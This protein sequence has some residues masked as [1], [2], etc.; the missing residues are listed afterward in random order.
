MDGQV[1][2]KNGTGS[3]LGAFFDQCSDGFGNTVSW[4]LYGCYA[5]AMVPTGYVVAFLLLNMWTMYMTFWAHHITNELKW[6]N[7][8]F[9]MTEAY[10][11]QTFL[12]T[13]SAIFG[14]Q[15]FHYDLLSCFSLDPAWGISLTA[16]H[17]LIF[18]AITSYILIYIYIYI[19]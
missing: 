6:N 5:V 1:A 9:G 2:R 10:I 14:Y 19:I 17:I 4:V 13:L 18:M 15:I 11:M 8:Q 3:S 12:C 16:L 7:G